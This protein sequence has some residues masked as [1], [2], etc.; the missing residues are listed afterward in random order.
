MPEMDKI[1]KKINK[2]FSTPIYN[3]EKLQ[4]GN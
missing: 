2:G 3:Y 1:I 4:G